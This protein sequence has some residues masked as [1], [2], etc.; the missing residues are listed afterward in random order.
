MKKT[1]LILFFAAVLLFTLNSC[2]EKQNPQGRKL[3]IT[4]NYP[5]T[6][7]MNEIAGNNEDVWCIIPPG[8]TE[9]TYAPKPS[10]IRLVENSAAVFYISDNL[11]AWLLN[12]DDINKIQ[13]LDLLPDSLFRYFPG[14][15]RSKK[16]IDPHFWTDPVI[17]KH[18]VPKLLEIMLR[19]KPERK[20]V[21]TKNAKLLTAKLNAFDI[22]IRKALKPY[23]GRSLMLFHPSFLYFLNRYGLNY[24]GSVEPA[25]GK[26]PTLQDIA[27]LKKTIEKL[28]LKA[29]YAEPQLPK[30]SLKILT[31]GTDMK[32]LELDPIGGGEGKHN[33]F[34]LM[35]YNYKNIIKGFAD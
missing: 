25:P 10:D 32:I 26:Q 15:A 23:R 5:I 17:M 34:E 14:S 19:Y 6:M 2:G 7:L 27:T 21:Y 28:N 4:T 12:F 9:H 35:R 11:D 16:N 13:L 24:A 1:I 33:Y 3:F 30:R 8:A 20:D 31:H 18:L 29:V 22:E